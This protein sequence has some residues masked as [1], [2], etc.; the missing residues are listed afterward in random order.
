MS[1]DHPG[2]YISVNYTNGTEKKI[3]ALQKKLGINSSHPLHTTI[4]HS[5]VPVAV[6]P[7]AK[8]T[9]QLERVRPLRFHIFEGKNDCKILV[10]IVES[11]FLSNRFDD[12]HSKGAVTD[13]IPYIPHIT[14]DYRW[15]G[16]LPSDALLEGL[17]LEFKSETIEAMSEGSWLS[18]EDSTYAPSIT[19]NAWAHL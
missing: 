13:Y 5:T 15:N 19:G 4:V 2:I 11:R 6:I 7:T 1:A 14:L 18:T 3:H 12:V 16:E 10:L 8:S 9:L 17:E